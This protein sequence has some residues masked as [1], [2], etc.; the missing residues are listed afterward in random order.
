MEE[1]PPVEE[2]VEEE[3]PVEEPMEEEPVEEEPPVEEPKRK[4]LCLLFLGSWSLLL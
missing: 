1:E 3:P 2:P 4:I